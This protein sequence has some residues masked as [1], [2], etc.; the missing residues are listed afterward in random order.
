MEN[1]CRIISD[2][3]PGGTRV[4]MPDGTP[5]PNVIRVE[6]YLDADGSIKARLDLYTASIDAVVTLESPKKK[7]IKK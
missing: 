1:I 3:S 5:I 2:G 4:L 6:W 7:R